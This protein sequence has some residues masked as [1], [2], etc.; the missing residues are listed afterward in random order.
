LASEFTVVFLGVLVALAVDQWWDVQQDRALEQ[1]YYGSLAEDLARDTAEYRY[2]F[3][4]MEVSAQVANEVLDTSLGLRDFPA[5]AQRLFRASFL[6]YPQR[7]TATIDELMS[8]G[9]LRLL[10]DESVKAAM[11]AYYRDVDEWQPRIRGPEFTQATLDYRREIQDLVFRLEPRD[12]VRV[13]D[14]PAL[15]QE[16]RQRERLP[17]IISTM[18]AYQSRQLVQYQRQLDQAESL[19]AILPTPHR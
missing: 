13:L 17:A 8:S 14:A 19:I 11:L 12:G 9:N 10:R 18:I 6:N 4:V 5:D 3:E 15:S 1:A 7:S 16:L 2:S